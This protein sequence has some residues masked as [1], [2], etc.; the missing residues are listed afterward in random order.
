MTASLVSKP[1]TNDPIRELGF[2]SKHGVNWSNYLAYRPI[3]PTSFFERIYDYHAQKPGALWLTAHDVGAGCGIVSATLATR[4]SSVIVSDPNDGYVALARKLLIE[5][6]SLPES[7]F[8]FR[9][10]PAEKSTVESGVVDLITACE[11]LHWTTPDVAI[12]EFGRELRAG[13]TLAITYYSRPLME[14]RERVQEAWKA[15]WAAHS[16]KSQDKIFNDAYRIANAGFETFGFPEEE[17]ETVKRVYINTQG[18]VSAFAVNGLI[19]ERRVKEHEEKIWIEG[20]KDW[21]DMK[22]IEW[23]KGYIGTWAPFIPESDIQE[24]WDELEL[25]LEGKQVKVRTPVVMI[26]ATKRA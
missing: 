26:L 23:L 9:Q 4:F 8:K 7:K 13:G 18:N 22:G 10:E 19:G 3:Y 11:C 25:A 6:S 16:R 17:W 1:E 12:R 5:E 20:D 2:S 14:G 24:A 15:V 21:S